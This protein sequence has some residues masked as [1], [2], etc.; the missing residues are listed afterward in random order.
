MYLLPILLK[1][2]LF[3]LLV[4][5]KL[6][7]CPIFYSIPHLPH[8]NNTHPFRRA[9]ESRKKKDKSVTIRHTLKIKTK[10]IL[11]YAKN[12]QE[13]K[14]GMVAVPERAWAHNLQRFVQEV[15]LRLQAE[16]SCNSD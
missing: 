5:S 9:N 2:I 14:N 7:L 12:E 13:K 6:L 15:F 10:G 11:Y 16:L 3:Q 1:I 8:K 4:N